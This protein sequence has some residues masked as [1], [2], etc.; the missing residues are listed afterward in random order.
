M[1]HLDLVFVPLHWC[2]R[3]HD[4]WRIFP[5]LTLSLPLAFYRRTYKNK[6]NVARSVNGTSSS[7]EKPNSFGT[8]SST[9]FLAPNAGDAKLKQPSTPQLENARPL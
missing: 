2:V 5:P 8:A 9:A 1:R 3:V 4:H 6:S 7:A